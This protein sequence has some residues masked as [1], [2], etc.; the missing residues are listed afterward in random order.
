MAP[1]TL[2]RWTTIRSL[3]RTGP[4]WGWSSS[5]TDP[6]GPRPTTTTRRSFDSGATASGF[7]VEP[8]HMELSEPSIG[9]A[10]DACV[11]AGADTVVVAPYFL[12]P[13][14]HWDRDIPALTA[15]AAARHPGVR[16]LVSAPLGPHPALMD[17]VGTRVHHCLA[18]ASGSAPECELV[19]GPVGASCADPAR[20][21]GLKRQRL[22]L[23]RCSQPGPLAVEGVEGHGHRVLVGLGTHCWVGRRRGR[24]VRRPGRRNSRWTGRTGRLRSTRCRC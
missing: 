8:A 10:F 13:G 2:R 5:T 15:E 16:S 7:V 17:V 18:H 1:P 12:W 19:P 22:Q 6:D 3:F 24:G 4:R 11:A 9:T 23:Q 20:R 14:S 21:R